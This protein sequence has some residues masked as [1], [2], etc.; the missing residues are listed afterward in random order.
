[1]VSFYANGAEEFGWAAV[2]ESRSKFIE[3]ISA[4]KSVSVEDREKRK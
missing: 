2:Q 1:M 3:I 4:E